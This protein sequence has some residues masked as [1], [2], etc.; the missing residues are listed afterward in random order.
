VRRLGVVD[1]D[2]LGMTPDLDD[3]GRT[4][5]RVSVGTFGP[6]KAALVRGHLRG[7][8]LLAFGDAVTTTDRELLRSA[9]RPFAVETRGV[10]REAAVAAG[11]PLL[12][13]S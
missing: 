5:P 11:M 13:M 10:H 4:L 7:R 9:H 1:D 2:V 3:N 6:D 12:R 8:P